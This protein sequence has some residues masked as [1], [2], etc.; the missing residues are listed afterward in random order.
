MD[1]S[2]LKGLN[3]EVKKRM[4][5]QI[6]H[7]RRELGGIRTGRASVNILDSVHVEAYG[8]SMPLNQVDVLV[9]NEVAAPESSRMS[10]DEITARLVQGLEQ[11]SHLKPLGKA[12]AIGVGGMEGR[13]VM[14]QSPSPFP[15]TNGEPQIEQDW[16]VTF[17]HRDGSVTFMI[18]VAPQSDFTR[19]QPT[20]ESILKSVQLQ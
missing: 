1:V 7:V 5:A 20:Y 4:D 10:L 6:E 3:A 9:L 12:E 13:S 2:D 19:F 14:L 17:P 11:G 16:L 18:F 15:A 8:S